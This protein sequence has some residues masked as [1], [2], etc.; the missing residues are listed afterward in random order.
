MSDE[1]VGGPAEAAVSTTEIASTVASTTNTAEPPAAAAVAIGAPSAERA[2]G[3]TEEAGQEPPKRSRRPSAESNDGSESWTNR[4]WSWWRSSKPRSDSA[5]TNE[6]AGGATA[7]AEA[8]SSAGSR[9]TTPQ[10]QVADLLRPLPLWAHS[11]S[12]EGSGHLQSAFSGPP[13]PVLD[14]VRR[15]YRSSIRRCWVDLCGRAYS[16]KPGSGTAADRAAVSAMNLAANDQSD[17]ESTKD[18][19]QAVGGASGGSEEA[20]LDLD[21]LLVLAQSMSGKLDVESRRFHPVFAQ[22]APSI[23]EYA[24]E[25][26]GKLFL[27]EQLVPALCHHCS[28]AKTPE[29]KVSAL[30]HFLPLWRVMSRMNTKYGPLWSPSQLS[31]ALAHVSPLVEAWVDHERRG[32]DSTVQH[33]K[34]LDAG[35]EWT[36]SAPQRGVWHAASLDVLFDAIRSA[37]HAFQRLRLP[38]ALVREWLPHLITHIDETLYGYAKASLIGVPSPQEVRACTLH[39]NVVESSGGGSSSASGNLSSNAPPSLT[40]TRSWSLSSL[41]RGGT[42]ATSARDAALLAELRDADLEPLLVRAAS[43]TH[44]IE[45]IHSIEGLIRTINNDQ[46]PSF[47]RAFNALTNSSRHVCELI[48]CKVILVDG[49]VHE[50]L[51]LPRVADAPLRVHLKHVNLALGQVVRCAPRPPLREMV[52]RSILL[53]ACRAFEHVLLYNRLGA[54]PRK[55]QPSDVPQLRED[56]QLMGDFFMARDG[57][58]VPQGV[59]VTRVEEACRPLHGLLVLLATPSELLIRMWETAEEAATDPQ[60]QPR[61]AD[62]DATDPAAS[63]EAVG[64][65][66]KRLSDR[67]RIARVLSQRSDEAARRWAAAA[68]GGAPEQ[69]RYWVSGYFHRQASTEIG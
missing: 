15:L 9:G 16:G 27:N 46:I 44:A 8:P 45:R 23:A 33:M 63:E 48:G 1:K 42:A 35:S 24:A 11:G 50:T 69:E 52:V 59:P 66:E 55:Y 31:P 29:L 2:E 22:Y 10:P 30:A 36:P 56:L 60:Q 20:T 25:E 57:A 37:L 43:L 28:A 64:A 4:W 5:E 51:Y 26:W 61:Q 67:Q 58:G 65:G 18:P 3:A 68:P 54:P 32:I 14:E 38:T 21:Q 49:R 13:P 41:W 19:P 17:S 34:L 12:L 40:S 39:A 47:A 53:E 62:V 7:E 6:Q